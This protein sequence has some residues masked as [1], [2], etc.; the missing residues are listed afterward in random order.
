MRLQYKLCTYIQYEV[1][2][3]TSLKYLYCHGFQLS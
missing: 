2:F 3:E 1:G